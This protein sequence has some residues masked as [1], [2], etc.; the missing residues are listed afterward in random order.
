[1]DDQG[2][3]D[4]SYEIF[5]ECCGKAASPELL[6]S[7]RGQ[8]EISEKRAQSLQSLLGKVEGTN[9]ADV[10]SHIRMLDIAVPSDFQNFQSYMT[11]RDGAS[12]LI[13]LSLI[14]SAQTSWSLDDAD[15]S[16]HYLLAAM[17]GS[18]RRLDSRDPDDYDGRDTIFH[19][20]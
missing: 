16:A 8:L 6:Q 12:M 10:S 3:R 15:V 13:Q 9:R 19:G 20:N 18:F 17:K 14:H 5:V 1:M 4:V 2:L 11:W 7:M